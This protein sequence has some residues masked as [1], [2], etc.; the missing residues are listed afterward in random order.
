MESTPKRSGSKMSNNRDL[1]SSKSTSKKPRRT[2][3]SRQ[4]VKDQIKMQENEIDM[5]LKKHFEKIS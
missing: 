4:S 2:K 1:T 3:D 5:K